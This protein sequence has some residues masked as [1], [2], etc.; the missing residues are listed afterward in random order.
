MTDIVRG[1]P[2]ALVEQNAFY[3]HLKMTLAQ[4]D[5]ELT[6]L[7]EVSVGQKRE[8]DILKAKYDTLEQSHQ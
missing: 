1:A 8:L 7:K 3:L 6:A 2:E 4:R 5:Q